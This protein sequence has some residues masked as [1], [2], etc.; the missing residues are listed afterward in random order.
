MTKLNIL[1][2][3]NYPPEKDGHG[4][5]KRTAQIL[6]ILEQNNC[7][8]TSLTFDI[9]KTWKSLKWSKIVV[10]F[11]SAII[12]FF[13]KTKGASFKRL[14]RQERLM[15]ISKKIISNLDN[16]PDVF[17]WEGTLE[18]HQFIAIELK[19]MGVKIL[20]ISH[21]LESLVPCD[22]QYG[23]IVNDKSTLKKFGHE[24]DTFSKCD[25]VFVISREEQW[26]VN[27]FDISAQYLPY[28][29][30][31]NTQNSLLEIREK[32]NVKEKSD[33]FLILGTVLNPPTLNGT[34]ALINTIRKT[35]DQAIFHIAGYG[36]EKLS[37]YIPENS[38]I[39]LH[40]SVTQT[41]LDDLLTKIDAILI[42]QPYTSGALTRIPEMLIAG[43]PV[44]CNEAAARSYFNYHG[45]YL[46]HDEVDLNILLK[47]SLDTP[48]IPKRED[49]YTDFFIKALKT[50][51]KL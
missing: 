8:Y 21:N 17:I 26:L 33:Q 38:S 22:S 44:I 5:S 43:I 15:F 24:I 41:V 12:K 46:F 1:H 6:E 45:V 23:T 50:D 13:F 30:T 29:P 32:R 16:V 47:K 35:S 27:L 36:T 18:I 48:I 39:I 14:R 7:T 9:K 34:I 37:A 28:Y 31:I 25:E 11:L 51:A 19:K 20:G 42:N 49:I 40:G 4:G 10:L 3:S 2:H